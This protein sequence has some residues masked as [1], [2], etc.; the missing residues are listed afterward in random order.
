MSE[1]IHYETFSKKMHERFPLMFSKPYG[2]FD[3]GEGWYDIVETLCSHIQR[4]IDWKNEHN[5]PVPQVVVNQIKEKFGGLRF[6]YNGGDD[7]VHGMVHIAEAWASHSCETCGDKG[8]RRGGG[9]I[10]T[11]CDKHEEERQLIMN[12]RKENV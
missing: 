8:K 6:Y 2:G 12:E 11:L 7:T 9:W 10:R 3:V 4:H 1:E 5:E